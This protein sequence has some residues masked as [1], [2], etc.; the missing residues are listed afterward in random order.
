VDSRPPPGRLLTHE[1][2]AAMN[3][4]NIDTDRV[5][6]EVRGKYR[7]VALQPGHASGFCTGRP[8]AETAGLSPR[9]H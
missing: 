6:R 5:R 1:P 4:D 2:K 7:E 3:A 9:H 8:L